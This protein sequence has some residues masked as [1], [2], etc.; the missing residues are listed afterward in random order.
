MLT[1]EEEWE[2]ELAIFAAY[3]DETLPDYYRE[4]LAMLWKAYCELSTNP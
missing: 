2:L 4:L 3:N 1:P